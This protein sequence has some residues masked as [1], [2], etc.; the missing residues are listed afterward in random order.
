MLLSVNSFPHDECV[1]LMKVEEMI[2]IIFLT[3]GFLEQ[4]GMSQ[5]IE[6]RVKMPHYEKQENQLP[7]PLKSSDILIPT[8]I[9]TKLKQLLEYKQEEKNKAESQGSTDLRS[10]L[11]ELHEL[12]VAISEINSMKTDIAVVKRKLCTLTFLINGENLNM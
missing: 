10:I 7:G 4:L 11:H 5:K 12:K 6:K 8:I 3:C 9:A 1:F 2:T